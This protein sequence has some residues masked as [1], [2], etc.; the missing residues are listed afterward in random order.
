MLDTIDQITYFIE[1]LQFRVRLD[2][3][4][5][6]ESMKFANAVHHWCTC[7]TEPRLRLQC[8]SAQCS[9]SCS[10]LD[11]LSFVNDHAL[12]HV[13]YSEN[14]GEGKA[15]DSPVPERIFTQTWQARAL[16]IV[17]S[18]ASGSLLLFPEFPALVFGSEGAKSRKNHIVLL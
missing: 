16:L 12:F 15:N 18:A 17:K 8:T 6:Y 14:L 4:K 3:E 5:L 10:I 9:F 2:A 13:R 1:L 11:A 7:K